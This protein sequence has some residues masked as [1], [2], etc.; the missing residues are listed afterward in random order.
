MLKSIASRVLITCVGIACLGG[1]V[2]APGYG[3]SQPY[4]TGYAAPYYYGYPPVYGSVFV[5]GGG[6]YGH[7]G[8][9]HGGWHGGEH[10]YGG[11]H[12]SGGQ[13]S[14]DGHGGGH[15]GGGHGGGHR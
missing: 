3:Y 1:C 5:G 11:G 13:W 6:Y 7:N 10:G 9:W 8:Y 15:G 14:G 2:V 4:D 12:G